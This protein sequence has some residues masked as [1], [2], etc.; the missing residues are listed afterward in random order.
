M[1][2]TIQ[3]A[4]NTQGVIWIIIAAMLA[5]IVRGFSGFGTAMIFL[6]VASS[7]FSPITAISVLT[8]MDLI[9][10]V[11]LVP[12]M[13]RD[14][15]LTELRKLLIGMIIIMPLATFLLTAMRPELFR[16]IVS[17]A[18][19]FLLLLL[20]LGVR[21]RGVL[22]DWML[23][24]TGALGGMLG[25]VAGLPGPPVI[26]IYMASNSPIKVIRAN[27]F[28]FL[29]IFEFAIL[30]VFA[31]RDLLT[32]DIII[33]GAIISV[34]YLLCNILGQCLFD[35]KKEQIY[36]NTVYVL[37]ALSALYGLPLWND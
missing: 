16:Y 11:P 5:G 14:A 25:G 13:I 24:A 19:L 3:A 20:I 37:I 35:P 23:Y 32:L 9:G 6:P 36:R 33:I 8:V 26:M 31:L 18:S 29:F 15:R 28:L 4:L 27:N 1:L 10:P 2:D 21:Y 22:R 30:G 7:I 12:R 17:I 34:P